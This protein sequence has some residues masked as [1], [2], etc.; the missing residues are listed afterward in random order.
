MSDDT[1]LVKLLA[2]RE[3]D[4]LLYKELIADIERLLHSDLDGDGTIGPAQTQELFT[5][6][7]S[8][9]RI[10]FDGPDILN[11]GRTHVAVTFIGAGCGTAATASWTGTYEVALPGLPPSLAWGDTYTSGKLV[12]VYT[13]NHKDPNGNVLGQVQISLIFIAGSPPTVGIQQSK[14]GDIANIVVAPDVPLTVTPVAPLLTRSG[15]TA[16]PLRAR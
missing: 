12:P 7:F 6:A 10:S 13:W 14:T 4:N 11:I 3:P 9:L 5:Y 16:S 8:D 1:E 2:T 15:A